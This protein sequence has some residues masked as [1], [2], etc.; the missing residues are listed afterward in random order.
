MTSEQRKTRAM[1]EVCD[2]IDAAGG[3]V[4]DAEGSGMLAPKGC[5]KWVD[6]ASAYVAACEA[7]GRTPVIE[8]SGEEE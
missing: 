7:L 4:P 5:D 8:E 1:Q 6:L 3:L 2:A